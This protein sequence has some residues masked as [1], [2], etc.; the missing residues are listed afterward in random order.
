MKASRLIYGIALGAILAATPA[1]A[2]RKTVAGPSADPKCFT[3]WSEKTK[4]FQFDKKAGPYRI[5]LANGFIAN[6]WRIQMIKTAKA[7]AAQPRS[8]PS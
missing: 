7:Y 6:T 8:R 1:L 4:Y 5:A 3:P 2:E